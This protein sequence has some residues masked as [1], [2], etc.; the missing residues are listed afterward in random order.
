MRTNPVANHR[1]S[2]VN[3]VE[4]WESQGRKQIGNVSMSR[5]FILEALRA[6]GKINLDGDKGNSCLIHPRTSHNVETCPI[7]EELLQGMMNKGQIEVCN[8]KKGK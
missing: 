2:T 8:A 6:A 7:V 4:E 3:A 1:G 5:R